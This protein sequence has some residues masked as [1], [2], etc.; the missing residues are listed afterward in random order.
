MT[1]AVDMG[2]KATKTN[3]KQ[4]TLSIL[5]GS[6]I[7]MGIIKMES[8]F[9]Y[10]KFVLIFQT[11]VAC[12]FTLVACQ[13]GPE[14]QGRPRSDCFWR[15][16]LTRVFPVC[17]SDKHFVNS[18]PDNHY[19]IREQKKKSIWNFRT[20]TKLVFSPSSCWTWVYLILKK[21]HKIDQDQLASEKLIRIYS[22]FHSIRIL[23]VTFIKS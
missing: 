23:K 16:S 7:Q 20:F 1:I 13:K 5:L 2:R 9:M 19:F 22:V 6:S 11:L 14:K 21:Q 18:N 15:S 17:Y 3:K 8:C 4:T 12:L 10:G